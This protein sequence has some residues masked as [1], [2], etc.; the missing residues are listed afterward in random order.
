LTFSSIPE[1]PGPF[2]PDGRLI[3]FSRLN[4]PPHFDDIWVMN[5]DGTGQRRLPGVA[6]SPDYATDW[7]PDGSRLFFTASPGAWSMLAADGSDKRL[8]A[9]SGAGEGGGVV[10]PDGRRMAF[11]S[12]FGTFANRTA[13]IYTT[14]LDGTED[15]VRLT[16]NRFEE[17]SPDYSP[18]GSRLAFTSDRDGDWDVYTM[19]TDGSG[20]LQVTNLPRSEVAVAWSPD[21]KHIAFTSTQEDVDSPKLYIMN[22]DGT[23]Q[24]KVSDI[25]INGG[26][27]W[28]PRQNRVPDCAGLTVTPAKLHP[29]NRKFRKVT[30]D[31]ATDA[32][33][34]ALAYT[35]D[36]VT[37]DEPVGRDPDARRRPNPRKVALRAERDQRGDGRVYRIAVTVADG[38]GGQCSGAVVVEVRRHKQRPA[39][40]SAPPSYDSFTP[41]TGP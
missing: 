23:G 17:R 6:D 38:H 36:G 40:D 34:D 7:S 29:P 5:A 32:D 19:N 2:S 16:N 11:L 22:A 9:D 3:A 37:Q 28:G 14:R 8:E 25:V 39:I 10:S 35:I 4:D 33:G 26:I 12:T 15:W 1:D 13:D 24:R 18:D 31:G 30:I 20:V 41:G 21:G 27:D